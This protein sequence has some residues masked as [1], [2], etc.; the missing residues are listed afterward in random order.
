MA[1]RFGYIDDMWSRMGPNRIENSTQSQLS[2]PLQTGTLCLVFG[3]LVGCTP[4]L[5]WVPDPL[6]HPSCYPNR[7][8]QWSD[9][10][11]QKPQ[12]D[13]R[14]AV[15]GIHFELHKTKRQMTM[16]FDFQRSW[17]RED[18]VNPQNV[19]QWRM[20]EQLLA[21]EQVHFLIYCLVA[22]QA[23]LT[24]KPQDNIEK[25]FELT[26]SVAQRLN[27]QYDHDTNH[28]IN[29]QA[30]ESWEREVMRQFQELGSGSLISSQIPVEP[31][32]EF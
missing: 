17:V 16:A 11:P 13:R 30:Q 5:Y 24:L 12:D 28:G 3:L 23:N 15:T 21:H 7:L 2:T 1:T 10:K 9:F 27:L 8:P 6:P 14:G 32:H 18:L 22:R 20:S 29:L 19:V 4:S 25:V 31:N 26:K